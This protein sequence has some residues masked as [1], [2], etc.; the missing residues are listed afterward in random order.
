MDFKSIG[1]LL[2]QIAPTI[3]TALGGPIAGM[4]VKT[5]STA[6]FGH[7]D[8]T[9]ADISTAIAEANPETLAK[10]KQIDADFKVRMKQLDIDLEK[11][12]SD[13]R[14]SARGREMVVRDWTPRILAAGV[15]CGYFFVLMWM[16]NKGMP[17]SGA[18]AML[19]MLGALQ[20]GFTGVLSYY[21]GSSAGSRAKDNALTNLNGGK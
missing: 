20:T 14:D 12:A 2:Q 18:E 15:C 19:M 4:A 17:P 13:D 3:A 5:L 21:F 9:E 6:I 8:G 11:I 7:G 16:F 10:I 1:P